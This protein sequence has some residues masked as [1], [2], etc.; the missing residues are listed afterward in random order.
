MTDHAKIRASMER[1]FHAGFAAGWNASQS[2]DYGNEP[3]DI[4]VQWEG[5]T[6][7]F[8]LKRQAITIS[9][10]LQLPPGFRRNQG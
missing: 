4:A 9:S 1:L 6:P 5:T 2:G 3:P 10:G 7:T 8:V